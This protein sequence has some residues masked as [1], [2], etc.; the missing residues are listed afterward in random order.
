MT[1]FYTLFAFVFFAFIGTT[2]AQKRYLNEVFADVNLEENIVYGNNITVLPALF[3][4]APAPADLL[5]NLLTPAG[6]TETDRPLIVLFHTGNFLPQLANGSINGTISDP[7]VVSI[8]ERLTRM[9]Y[10]VALAD[11][12]QGWNPISADQGVR[13]STLI[14][15]AYRGVQDAA[16]CARF[17]RKSAKN[18]NAYGI[19][20]TK[21][22]VWGV[23]TGGYVSLAAASLDKYEDVLLPKFIGSDTLGNPVPMVI[24]QINGDPKGVNSAPL[25]T[26]SHVDGDYSSEYQLCVNMG[27]AIGD[28]SWLDESDPPM[29]SFHV[30]TDPFAPY[31]EGTVIVPT[32]G[33]LVVDVVG[34]YAVMQKADELGNNAVFADDPKTESV[35]TDVANSR[36]DGYDGLF[37]LPRPN[38]DIN[39]N[40]MPVNVEASPWEF[41]DE[42][43]W[44]TAPW[45]QATLDGMGATCE[46]I[47]I[48]ACNWH[49]ISLRTNPD[50]S[51][52]KAV[53]YQD[54]IINYF[55]PR[56][57]LALDLD[58]FSDGVEDQILN[59]SISV[60][61]N[62]AS[63]NVTLNA[64]DIVIES[65]QIMDLSGRL[66]Q[67]HPGVNNTQ[68]TFNRADLK[69]GVY[70]AQLR[71]E[72]GNQTVRFVIE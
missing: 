58:C 61:P 32:T 18:G 45:G 60:V 7:Y 38:W 52:N 22:A 35:Y 51:I 1:K 71:F 70:L 8:G 2:D 49:L 31:N 59:E 20:S 69:S 23:G 67:S 62:P 5:L 66:V 43:F 48:E 44:S 55:A 17:F 64:G 40:G 68:F 13:T 72:N 37:P 4:G 42:T 10:V 47:P 9:G 6:D 26:P 15:A 63:V 25:N 57:C 30:P 46:G 36:N 33:D 54:S 28:I 34:S 24:E 39:M 11:Y 19:D 27:G 14:N 3:G 65:V 56:A 21:I 29:I 12:R 50:M 41:W 53:A 16:T